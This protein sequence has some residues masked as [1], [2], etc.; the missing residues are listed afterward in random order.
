MSYLCC[1]LN[2]DLAERQNINDGNFKLIDHFCVYAS[3]GQDIISFNW[4]T[5]TIINTDT[6]TDPDTT[7]LALLTSLLADDVVITCCI[8]E[9]V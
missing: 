9:V 7:I 8:A 4:T 6:S 1:K 2:S 3:S 5:I